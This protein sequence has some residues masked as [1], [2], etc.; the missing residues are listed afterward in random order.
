MSFRIKHYQGV[1]IPG[2][3]KSMAKFQNLRFKTYIVKAAQMITIAKLL[4]A[5]PEPSSSC[6]ALQLFLGCELCSEH[7]GKY[8]W[9]P[10]TF[11]N[12]GIVLWYRPLLHT[13][14][15]SFQAST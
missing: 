15:G 4:R 7:A 13:H 2:K 11:F 6:A 12:N 14:W 5:H 1:D 9:E 8:E 3:R 10:P